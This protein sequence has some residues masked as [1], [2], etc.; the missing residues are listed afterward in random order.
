MA[1][2]Q[3]GNTCLDY[4]CKVAVSCGGRTRDVLYSVSEDNSTLLE[5]VC[6]FPAQFDQ[7]L[8]HLI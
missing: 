2:L 7:E 5:S 4:Q 3:L 6:N 1:R 8:A